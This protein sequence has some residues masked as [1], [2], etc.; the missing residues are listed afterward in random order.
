M[1]RLLGM[2][3]QTPTET[4]VHRV[5]D[6]RREVNVFEQ[7]ITELEEENAKLRAEL[8]A[9]MLPYSGHSVQMIDGVPTIFM[10]SGEVWEMVTTGESFTDKET[11]YGRREWRKVGSVPGSPAARIDACAMAGAA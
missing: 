4:L 8:A 1:S 3:S 11:N 2:R 10:G 6:L 7:R 9:S 5:A